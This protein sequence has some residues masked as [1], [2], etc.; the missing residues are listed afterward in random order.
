LT[1][2]EF[3]NFFEKSHF[4]LHSFQNCFWCVPLPAKRENSRKKF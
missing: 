4:L 3:F 2:M 1:K